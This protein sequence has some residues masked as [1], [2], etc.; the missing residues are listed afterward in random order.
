[1]DSN[2]L[3]IILEII[4]GI[5]TCIILVCKLVQYVQKYVKEK[6]WPKM[7]EFLMGLMETAEKKFSSGAKRKEW[8]MGVM[9]E[10]AERLNYNMDE[11]VVSS[12]IDRMC[13]MSNI[14]NPGSKDSKEDD[15]GETSTVPPGVA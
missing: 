9:K 11:D 1:M 6:N 13:D 8:V 7:L 4:P 15:K 5:A 3:R 14:V 12:M 10:T 2:I